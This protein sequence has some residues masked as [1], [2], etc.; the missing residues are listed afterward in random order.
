[1]KNPI[2]YL[3]SL[4]PLYL[5]EGYDHSGLQIEGE[6]HSFKKIVLCLD[7]NR[8]VY[9]ECLPFKPDCIISHHPFF[10]GDRREI[11]LTNKQKQQLTFDVINNLKCPIYSFHTNFDNAKDGMNQF[12]AEK[13]Q[14][15]DIKTHP[16]C[17]CLHYG[18]L[19]KPMSFDEFAKYVKNTF[20]LNYVLGLKNNSKPIQKVGIIGGAGSSY[21]LEAMM[22]G[23]DAFISGDF[24]HHVRQ[25]INNAKFNY[26]DIPHEV[27]HLFMEKIKEDLEKEFSDLEIKIVDDQKQAICY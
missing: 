4:Y 17:Q 18:Y 14:L 3:L 6:I 20:N 22:I 2:D 13:L 26:L 15:V 10:F 5:Q 27:E 24:V 25:D 21:Y 16:L 8:K 12:L 19:N 23:L 9:E 11:Y 1:M 7:F